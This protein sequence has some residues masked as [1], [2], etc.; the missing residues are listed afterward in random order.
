VA[1]P[2]RRIV[3]IGASAG[4]LRSLVQ[5]FDELPPNTGMAFV[6]LRRDVGDRCPVPV[7]A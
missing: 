3:G 4:G 6:P 1:G 7:P 2:P 5:L